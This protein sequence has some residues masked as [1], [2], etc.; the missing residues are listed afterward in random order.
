MHRRSDARGSMH[1]VA[2][3]RE[4]HGITFM[5]SGK[6][7]HMHASSLSGI[8]QAVGPSLKPL[9]AKEGRTRTGE[10]PDGAILAS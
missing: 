7:G 5:R 4:I 3:S 1:P 8:S 2:A 6:I 9:P 10:V